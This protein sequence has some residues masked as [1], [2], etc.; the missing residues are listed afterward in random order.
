MDTRQIA[1]QSASI[2]VRNQISL[3]IYSLDII[4]LIIT[5]IWSEFS[6]LTI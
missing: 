4:D 3:A 5:I 1:H 2:Q 6:D